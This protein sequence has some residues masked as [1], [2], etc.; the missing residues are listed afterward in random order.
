[1]PKL[2]NTKRAITLKLFF[3]DNYSMLNTPGD[4]QWAELIGWVKDS[5]KTPA[6]PLAAQMPTKRPLLASVNK[7][8]RC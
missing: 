7:I 6:R 5:G 2:Q 1:M 8:F 3:V 4:L